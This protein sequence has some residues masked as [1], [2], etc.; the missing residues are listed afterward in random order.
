MT[1][2]LPQKLMSG[3]ISSLFASLPSAAA[4]PGQQY[5]VSDVGIHGSNW[6]SDGTAWQLVGG[7]VVLFQSSIP[8]GVPPSGTIAANGVLTLGT[9]LD[10]T[11]PSIYMYFPAGAWTGSTA[12]MYYVSMS[13]TTVGQVYTNQYTG[14]VPVI[15]SSPAAV[16]TGA[17]AYTQTT[18]TY[19]TVLSYSLPGG[20]AG[21]SGSITSKFLISA[22][23]S[24][25]AKIVEPLSGLLGASGSIALTTGQGV[26]RTF[27]STN[28]STTRQIGVQAADGSNNV[29]ANGV[30]NTAVTVPITPKLY[31]PTATD[32]IMLQTYQLTLSR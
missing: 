30:N 13:S 31:I 15:P 26:L 19:L 17:G 32:W 25:G 20:V 7:Q 3:L 10:N 2:P 27:T 29:L 8:V 28:V 11:Y 4:V 1:Y 9:A 24:A 22:S 14:G 6:Q 21:P 18:G 5:F 12:G 16:S 23:N